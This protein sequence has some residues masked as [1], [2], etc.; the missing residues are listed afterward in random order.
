MGFQN[1]KVVAVVL[2]AVKAGTTS[3]QVTRLVYDLDDNNEPTPNSGQALADLISTAVLPSYKA[4]FSNSWGCGSPVV[5]EVIDPL[6]VA[7]P[8]ES[9]LGTGGGVGTLVTASD[10]LPQ[11]V[12]GLAPLKT[13]FRGRRFNGRI[14]VPGVFSEADQAGGI[15]GGGTVARMQAFLDSIPRQPDIATGPSTATAKWSV[16]SRTQRGLNL[17]PYLMPVTQ[18]IASSRVRWLRSRDT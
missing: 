13:G 11:A 5:E 17:D 1:G 8:R 3:T 4:L 15:F 2:T 6:D 16:F 12:C 14:F 7:A 9:W 10:L 18:A